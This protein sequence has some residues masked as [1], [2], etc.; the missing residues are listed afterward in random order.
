M[1][2]LTALLGVIFII[3]HFVAEGP[4]FVDV[5]AKMA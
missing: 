1:L 3:R 5:F 2:K 4:I